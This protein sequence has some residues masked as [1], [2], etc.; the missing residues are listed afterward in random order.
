M[1][2]GWLPSDEDA[3]RGHRSPSDGTGR[4]LDAR[5]PRIHVHSGGQLSA[6]LVVQGK[7]STEPDERGTGQALLRRAFI[8]EDQESPRLRAF[9]DGRYWART[10]DPQ[11]VE[12]VLSQLS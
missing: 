10:S 1:G 2:K 12:L 11:L 5:N 8:R 9:L 3:L 4:A 6:K 7:Q